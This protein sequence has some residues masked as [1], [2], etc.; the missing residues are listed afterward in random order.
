MPAGFSS[1]ADS[2]ATLPPKR[3]ALVAGPQTLWSLVGG[4]ARVIVAA[5]VHADCSLVKIQ[6]GDGQGEKLTNAAADIPRQGEQRFEWF[7]RRRNNVV[8]LLPREEGSRCLSLGRSR[9]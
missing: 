2:S 8:H 1:E 7:L 3:T 5:F 6:V 9:I 4:F